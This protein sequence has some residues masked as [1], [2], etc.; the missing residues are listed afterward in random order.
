MTNAHRVEFG[1]FE[2]ADCKF[3]CWLYNAQLLNSGAAFSP[4]RYRVQ[5]G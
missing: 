1:L 2:R 5:C 4:Y 3:P